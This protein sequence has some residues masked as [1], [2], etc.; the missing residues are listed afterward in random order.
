MNISINYML[1]LP[2]IVISITAALVMLADLFIWRLDR[3]KL[4][5]LAI[6]GLVVS[7]IAM[8]PLLDITA[9]TLSNNVISDQF[10]L[11]FK[12]LFVLTAIPIVLIS[13]SYFGKNFAPGEYLV[14]V[15]FSLV[16]MMIMVSTTDLLVLILGIEITSLS[17]YVLAGYH[18]T[19]QRANEASLKY[20]ILGIIAS[21]VLLYGMSFLYGVSGHTDLLKM[22]SVIASSRSTLAV[23]GLLLVLAAFSFKFA[24]APFHQWVPDVYEGAPTPVSAFLSVGP[25]IAAI[26][27]LLRLLFIG[28]PAFIDYWKIMFIILAVISMFVGNLVAISQKNIKRMLAY[29]SVAHVGYILIGVVVASKLA[30]TGIFFYT[31]AYAIMNIGAWAIVIAVSEGK[32]LESMDN[33][34]GLAK[35]SPFLALSMAIFM[36]AL[37]GLPPTSGLW[38][39]VYIFAAAIKGNLTWLALIGLLNSVISMYYYANVIRHMYLME[40]SDESTLVGSLPI[41]AVVIAMIIGVIFLGVLPQELTE[42]S[43]F[44]SYYGV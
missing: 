20:L 27:A 31:V 32:N 21:A 35:R 23:F 42:L 5:A 30:I 15:L 39:K 40:P 25:K 3:I 8:Y 26:A 41:K 22:S 4:S 36:V 34:K 24:A 29:S 18:K 12:I 13:Q 14:L 10:A 38:G 19:D 43:K 16:G 6:A 33:Y 7:L 11:F 37:I 9:T 2:E 28:F 17:S 1:F 44:W